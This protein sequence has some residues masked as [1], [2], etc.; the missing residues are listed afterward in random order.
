MKK[1]ILSIALTS[2]LS[3]YSVSQ[4][5]VEKKTI[6]STTGKSVNLTNAFGLNLLK[7]SQF[8]N[9]YSP[10]VEFTDLH[11]NGYLLRNEYK[12]VLFNN[13]FK[14]IKEIE[15]AGTLVNKNSN[16]E[17]HPSVQGIWIKPEE[18]GTPKILKVGLLSYEGTFVSKE[19]NITE[20]YMQYYSYYD[21]EKRAFVIY[22]K[23]MKGASEIGTYYSFKN[24]PNDFTKEETVEK[25]EDE[26]K[27]LRID[28]PTNKMSQLTQSDAFISKTT[29]T[30]FYAKLLT[31]DLAGNCKI[32]LSSNDPSIKE[33]EI[34]LLIT[35]YK[36]LTSNISASLFNGDFKYYVNERTNDF[37]IFHTI[38][39]SEVYAIVMINGNLKT[40][41]TKIKTIREPE[42]IKYG[43]EAKNL[44]K[45]SISNIL[46]QD[47]DYT[48]NSQNDYLLL[49]FVPRNGTGV[50][51]VIGDDDKTAPRNNADNMSTLIINN[52]FEL[53]V[54]KN[55]EIVK[56]SFIKNDVASLKFRDFKLAP[57]SIKVLYQDPNYKKQESDFIYDEIGKI[58]ASKNLYRLIQK[59]GNSYIFN[60]K[61]ENSSV[62]VWKLKF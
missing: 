39:K 18:N 37:F 25:T 23:Q 61:S 29:G 3:S 58:K 34:K 16:I 27:E 24:S 32:K 57:S 4:T 56:T 35:D 36:N 62:D 44:A 13:D 11:E 47:S 5:I 14:I 12:L 1:I 51:R 26:K 50:I 54:N 42:F 30:F 59:N 21:Y 43:I 49:D 10:M 2:L 38:V 22:T 40:D 20:K 9:Y 46:C 15:L 53:S 7:G 60:L 33:K 8:D 17:I 6:Y 19:I 41:D 55:L 45:Y 52:M 28:K 31:M 48:I